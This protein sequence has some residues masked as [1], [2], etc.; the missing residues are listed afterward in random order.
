MVLRAVRC[1]IAIPLSFF[2]GQKVIGGDQV[3]LF[4]S[5]GGFA[6]L[7]FAEFPGDRAARA[8]SYVML[9]LVGGA[10]IT[11]GTLLAE[12]EWLAVISMFVVGTAV[13]FVGVLSAALAGAGRAALLTFILPVT[14]P[15]DA[16]DIPERLTGWSVAC[17][18][19]IPAALYLFPPTDHDDLRRRAA[20]VCAALARLLDARLTD[21][22]APVNDTLVAA[23]EQRLDE[24][25]S[26][27]RGTLNRPVGLT[28][29]SRSL[30]RVVDELEWL[31]PLIAHVTPDELDHWEPPVRAAVVSSVR[32]LDACARVL[33]SSGAGND[34][35]IE[36]RHQLDAALQTSDA[37][38]RTG[39]DAVV[40]AVVAGGHPAPT[41]RPH[42][43]ASTTVLT[44]HSIAWAA[45]ADARSVFARLLGRG[46]PDLG[47]RSRMLG[48]VSPL[49]EAA[50]SYV[51]KGSVWLRNSIRGGF[52]LAIAVLIAGAFDVQH[53]FWVVLG[54][55]SVLRS[56]ALTTGSTGLR[57]IL[58]TV[59]G[60]VIGALLILVVG[61]G[62]LALWIVLPFAVFVASFA[63]AAI[64]F[65]A[66][67]A[68]FTIV[69]V[70]L[71]NLIHPVG[72]KVG[73][74]RI[75]DVAIGCGISLVVGLLLWPRGAASAIHTALADAYRAGADY[76]ARDLH[77]HELQR[78]L[79]R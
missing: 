18:I 32:V 61:T 3:A 31:A 49:R 28:A 64:S 79:S 25:R 9:G 7:V 40:A 27:F 8:A 23:V 57:A 12:P 72:W 10:L 13:L 67:Q 46:L 59:A 35:R 53:G 36:A 50:T 62:Q 14:I 42:E 4:A 21:P 33:D 30:V 11:L 76:F 65:A 6:L 20:R 45:M 2:V 44:G 47:A 38:R 69:V 52:G 37:A 19:C 43:I 60:F 29:G 71:F 41:F 70:V 15:V 51:T 24:L 54:A 48:Q 17:A 58:G 55:M 63:P 66:G 1:A 16:S 34:E 74:T 77:G 26:Q 68:A 56:S 22:R 5:F 78:R 73:L 39:F 75:E